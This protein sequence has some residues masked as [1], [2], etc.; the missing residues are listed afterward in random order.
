MKKWG[1]PLVVV[2][3]ILVLGGAAYL[4]MQNNKQASP[5]MTP[6]PTEVQAASPSPSSS[7]SA[8]PS[9]SGAMKQE[10][11]STVTLTSTGFS[12]ASITVKAGT[13]V[14]WVNNSGEVATVNSD[15]HPVHTDYPP[16]NLGQFPSGGSLSLVFD[17]PGT[18]GYHNHFN[19]SQ[20]GT[21]VVQ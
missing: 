21:I 14:T 1:I 10:S 16:L 7:T 13:K 19:P 2:A 17:K 9:V 6:S 11:S 20:K 15:P 12:P 18:Y 5:A 3:L 8:T 4:Y